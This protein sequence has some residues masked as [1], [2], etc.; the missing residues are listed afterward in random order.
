VLRTVARLAAGILVVSAASIA[1]PLPAQAATCGSTHG[2]SV[3]VDFHQLGGGVQSFCDAGGSGEYAAQQFTDAGH[4][5]TR[6]NGEPG[7][8]CRV[9]GAPSSDPCQHTPP[10]DAYWSLW[11]SDGKSGTW[12]YAA[13]GVDSLKVPAGGYVAL[14]WQGQSSQAKPRV[15]PTAHASSSPSPTPSPSAPPPRHRHHAVHHPS[16]HPSASPSAAATSNAPGTASAPSGNPS[17]PS[18]APSGSAHATHHHSAAAAHH[19]SH[20]PSPHASATPQADQPPDR[21]THPTSGESSSDSGLP[22]WIAPVL[23]ALVFVAGGAVTVV[24]RRRSGST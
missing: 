18:T 13:T 15:R 5:L 6:V 24:R 12:K 20:R 4:T 23:V 3:V 9:D 14:S 10:T 7:F 11:W 8:V 19:A 22:G 2:V 16:H 21:A 1:V 17:G